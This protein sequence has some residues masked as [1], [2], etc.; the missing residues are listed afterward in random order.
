ML[1]W[2]S[3]SPITYNLG[4]GYTTT[5]VLNLTSM[6]ATTANVSN[7]KHDMFCPGVLLGIA[8]KVRL[9]MRCRKGRRAEAARHDAVMPCR[10]GRIARP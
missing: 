3:Y 5:A 6:T 7:S 1:M 8:V 4:S 2:A 9:H 10:N